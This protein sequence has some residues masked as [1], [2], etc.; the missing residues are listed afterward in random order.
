ML[1]LPKRPE[2]WDIYASMFGGIPWSEIDE[3]KEYWHAFPSLKSAL[4]EN[5]SS[6]YCKLT[7]TD[8]KRSSR[9]IMIY[10]LL[11]TITMPPLMVLINICM[12]N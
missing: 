7:A 8:I 6:D 10:S 4:F 11:K 12:M 3:L 5:T 1:T 9:I 2:S